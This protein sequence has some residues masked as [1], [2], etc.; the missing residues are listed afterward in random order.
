MKALI[1]LIIFL[2]ILTSFSGCL[3]DEDS[4]NDGLPDSL[5]REGWSIYVTSVGENVSHEVHVTSSTHKKDTDGDG[6]TDFQEWSSSSGGYVTNPREKDTDG[7]G[8]TDYEEIMVYGTDPLDWRDDIDKDNGWWDSDYDE[9]QYYKSRGIDDATI[10]Q[11]LNN[12]DV[13]GDG[14]KDGSD[15]DPLEDLK[16]KITIKSVRI[17]SDMD[18]SDDLL[19]TIFDVTTDAETKSSS[20]F[21]IPVG[22]NYSV[23]ISMVVDLN[24][25]GI[26][27]EYNNSISINVVDQDKGLEYKPLDIDGLPGID[28]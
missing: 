16:V 28:V 27:G 14:I 24:D 3:G 26:P 20:L 10:K 5:E 6:L 17:T 1:P 21:Y 4:D 15:I 18:D 13:D 11:F 2:L 12:S 22:V 23:N 8:L 19:E 25:M 9:V 7:D